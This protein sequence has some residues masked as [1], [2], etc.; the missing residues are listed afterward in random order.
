MQTALTQL[1]EDFLST[2]AFLIVYFTTGELF[3]A[4]GVAGAIGIGQFVIARWRRRSI[5]VMQWLSLA[6]VVVLGGAALITNDSRFMMAKPSVVHFAIGAVMLRSGWMA[7][8][9]PPIVRENVPGRVLVASGYAWAALM[10]I[11]GLSN[12]YVAT[13]FSVA[14][15][16]WFISVGAF[17]AKAVAFVAQYLVF[18]LL[19]SRKLRPATL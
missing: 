10:F 8:Y 6:F 11:L 9:M 1:A 4:V 2:F 5:D 19:M 15:W 14:A 3:L 16:G 7:R 17:G 13:N 18:R 12:L